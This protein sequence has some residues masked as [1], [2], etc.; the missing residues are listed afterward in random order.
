MDGAGGAQRDDGRMGLLVTRP[1]SHPRPGREI[2]PCVSADR[3]HIWGHAG[4]PAAA[5]AESQRLCGALGTLGEG[6]V[7][8]TAYLVWGSVTPPCADAV[9]GAFSPRAESSRQGQ[10][11]ALSC[12]QPGHSTCRPGTVSRTAWRAPEILHV[13]SRL[14]F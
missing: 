1:V 10:R 13:R 4:A 2:L 5:V 14:S 9:C 6:G 11:A 7:P 3:R 12:C 8:V